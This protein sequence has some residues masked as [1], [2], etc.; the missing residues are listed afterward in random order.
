VTFNFVAPSV[1]KLRDDVSAGRRHLLLHGPSFETVVERMVKQAS[2]LAIVREKAKKRPGYFRP[3]ITLKVN[4]ST[5][6]LFHTSARGYRAQY[7]Q[8]IKAGQRA[9][10]YALR[11]LAPRV[12][13]LL[14]RFPKRT[15]PAAWV[16]RS[17]TDPAAKIW[18]HQGLW[19][20]H[21]KTAD[22]AL[23]V[24]RWVHEQQSTER[25]DPDNECRKTTR[26]QLARWGMLAPKSET[27]IDIKGAFISLD[28][29]SLGKLKKTRSKVNR[30]GIPGDSIS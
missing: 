21:A 22:A 13:E 29:A 25:V 23:F 24:K 14:H 3:S 11:M 18:I 27:R 20:R 5:V 19:L 8:S 1:W 4:Q 12:S 28:G 15:C 9:N 16:I 6:D 17:L 7:Y 26:G 10:A 30:P 2:L